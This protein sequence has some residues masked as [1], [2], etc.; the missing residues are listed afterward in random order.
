MKQITVGEMHELNDEA[1]PLTAEELKAGGWWCA[2][3]SEECRLA[4]AEKGLDARHA[5]WSSD[6]AYNYCYLS[7]NTIARAV[8]YTHKVSLKLI[9]RIVN[10]FYWSEK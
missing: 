7:G 6:K 4:F 1:K 5:D 2:D 9:R 10:E 8:V 3:V